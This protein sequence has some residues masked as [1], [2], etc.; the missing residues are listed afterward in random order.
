MRKS[1]TLLS[2]LGVMGAI[3][4]CTGNVSL[5]VVPGGA[6]DAG[7]PD[8]TAAETGN[9]NAPGTY[10]IECTFSF[11]GSK[12]AYADQKFTARSDDTKQQT[13]PNPASNV[14]V[15]IATAPDNAAESLLTVYVHEQDAKHVYRL[16]KNQ[17]PVA[18]FVGGHGFTGLQYLGPNLQYVCASPGARTATRSTYPQQFLA[19][20]CQ[21]DARSTPDGALEKSGKF[22]L[23][24][25]PGQF[26]LGEFK[27]F[28]H[29][30]MHFEAILSDDP[31][32]VR[33]IKLRLSRGTTSLSQ[34]FQLDRYAD[35]ENQLAGTNMSGRASIGTGT[36]KEI[37][38]VCTAHTG[39]GINMIDSVDGP[40]PLGSERVCGYR[41]TL[42]GPQLG[43]CETGE[44]CFTQISCS[45]AA[46]PP[47][48]VIGS[49]DFADEACHKLC[50]ADSDCGSYGECIK[51][52]RFYGGGVSND[53]TGHGICCAKG[54]NCE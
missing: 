23:T 52:R 42:S 47:T 35:A 19:V 39:D 10:D 8:A 12:V 4:A 38:Y 44:I 21:V 41:Q 45:G 32:D 48:C 15:S 9:A 28:D 46:D 13:L 24:T 11:D 2:A 33:S 37:S 40:A 36:S 22:W 16:T 17:Q 26:S 7:T 30:D 25:L 5:G 29:E 34:L 54:T 50:E 18:Q 6:N 51:T 31:S 49:K 1:P 14:D 3:A 20:M 43:A 53:V 27:V